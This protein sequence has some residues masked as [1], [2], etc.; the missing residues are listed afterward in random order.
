MY[1]VPKKIYTIFLNIFM[2]LKKPKL[3]LGFSLG[4]GKSGNRGLETEL[5]KASST[6]SSSDYRYRNLNEENISTITGSLK[7]FQRSLKKMGGLTN[8]QATKA[9]IT[10]KKEYY[11]HKAGKGN[12]TRE[13]YK[14]GKEIVEGLKKS[15][16]GQEVSKTNIVNRPGMY[17]PTEVDNNSIG[18]KKIPTH[19][20][21]LMI[22]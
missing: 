18:I 16:Q 9:K 1:T 12:F 19:I 5:K 7:P 10:L 2:P 8:K 6:G 14:D 17:D 13:D 15:N 21:A 4:K 11:K 22:Y 3:G 20:T